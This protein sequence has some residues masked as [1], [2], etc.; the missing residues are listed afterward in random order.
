MR[1]ATSGLLDRGP[2]G[3]IK[4]LA[5]SG[6]L[7]TARSGSR[8]YALIRLLASLLLRDQRCVRPDGAVDGFESSLI[9]GRVRTRPG[10]RLKL[11]KY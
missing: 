10:E 9:G 5:P 7:N 6:A 11:A 1:E 3:G 4:L 2:V 8:D